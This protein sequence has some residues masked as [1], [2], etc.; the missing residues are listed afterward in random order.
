[1]SF[2]AEKINHATFISSIIQQI[3]YCRSYIQSETAELDEECCWCSSEQK[4]TKNYI[5]LRLEPNNPSSTY[6]Q[7]LQ[8]TQSLKKS[9][10]PRLA[11]AALHTQIKCA[12]R[13]CHSSLFCDFL[14]FS[15]ASHHQPKTSTLIT[16]FKKKKQRKQK[17]CNLLLDD[18]E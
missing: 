7:L 15:N 13:N 5:N 14:L 17:N 3:Y 1:M 16:I 2:T 4:E 6:H 10:S 9:L 11:A 8:I 12:V 18:G